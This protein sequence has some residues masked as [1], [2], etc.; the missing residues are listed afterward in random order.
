MLSEQ[1]DVIRSVSCEAT[2]HG[3]QVG[4]EGYNFISHLRQRVLS[5]RGGR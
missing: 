5:S 1:G 2:P 4:A 3:A